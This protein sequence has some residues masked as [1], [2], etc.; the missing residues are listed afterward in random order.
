[1]S[2]IDINIEKILCLKTCFLLSK[3]SICYTLLVPKM[4]QGRC[5]S[6]SQVSSPLLGHLDGSLVHHRDTLWYR[7]KRLVNL[8]KH[9]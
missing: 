2:L 6:L 8:S 3:S 5:W 7:L 1:M 9:C 4:G